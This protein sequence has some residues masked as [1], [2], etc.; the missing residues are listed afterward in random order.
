MDRT[1][2]TVAL[3]ALPTLSLALAVP[4]RDTTRE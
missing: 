4:D 2:V 3:S 1:E